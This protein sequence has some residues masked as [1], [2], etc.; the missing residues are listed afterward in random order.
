MIE[1]SFDPQTA[2]HEGHEEHEGETESVVA[3]SGSRVPPAQAV[4][5]VDPCTTRDGEGVP[6]G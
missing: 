4:Y 6:A 3:A 5:P 1:V 2:D